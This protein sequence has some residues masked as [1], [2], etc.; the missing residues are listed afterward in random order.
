MVKRKGLPELNELVM[1]TVKRITPYAAWCDLDEYEVEGMVHVSEVAGKW[2]QD[3]REF[4]KPN[5]QYVARVVKIDEGK[6]IVNLS[7]KRLSRM[8]EKEKLNEFKRSEHAEKLLEQAAKGMGKS[9]GQA[10][11]E[12]GYLLQEKFGEIST[13]FDEARKDPSQLKEA[14]VPKKWIDVLSP[15]IE[16]NIKEKEII[17]KVDL[18]LKSFEGDGVERVKETLG[19]LQKSGMKVMYISAPKYLVEM[20]TKDPRNDEKKIRDLLESIVSNSKQ[21]KIDFSYKF[22]K[23]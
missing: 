12:V 1:C 8:D 14:G 23:G 20:K 18:D 4:V 17:L 19:K 11:D 21:M 22:V 5:K 3:I 16:K 6:R 10:Y 15:I 2:V 7:L 13:A 9:L